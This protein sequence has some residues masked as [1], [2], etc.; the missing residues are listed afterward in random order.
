MPVVPRADVARRV[1][2]SLTFLTWALADNGVFEATR[3]YADRE[4]LCLV[5]GK[6]AIEQS[7]ICSGLGE[8]LA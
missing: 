5:L 7:P 3:V 1:Y 6:E 8:A 4:F 2:R